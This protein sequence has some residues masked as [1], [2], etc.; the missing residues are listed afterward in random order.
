MSDI[1]IRRIEDVLKK[2]NE[3]DLR[4]LNHIIVE[5]LKLISQAKSTNQM[6]RFNI[7]EKVKFTGPDGVEK[8]GT[9]TKMHK[10]TVSVRIGEKEEWNISPGFLK[11]AD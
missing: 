7:G 5:R 2:F 6:S 9:I 3:E 1:D 8:N 10:K 4:Y 11:H